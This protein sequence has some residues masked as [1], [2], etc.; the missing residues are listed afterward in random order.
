MYMSQS[1]FYLLITMYNRM[2]NDLAYKIV[3]QTLNEC[4]CTF[5]QY[6]YMCMLWDSV[7]VWGD[8]SIIAHIDKSFVLWTLEWLA[9]FLSIEAKEEPNS[10][11]HHHHTPKQIGPP[12]CTVIRKCCNTQCVY[13]WTYVLGGVSTDVLEG[14]V[15]NKKLLYKCTH[16]YVHE[17]KTCR[18][19]FLYILWPVYFWNRISFGMPTTRGRSTVQSQLQNKQ[20]LIWWHM[21]IRPHIHMYPYYDQVEPS[22]ATFSI[23]WLVNHPYSW[24][25]PCDF[26]NWWK[27]LT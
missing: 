20:E 4:T 22:R 23:F 25:Y 3:V 10:W 6:I 17:E 12:N 5:H 27:L 14:A 24:P 19:F 26:S 1:L 8:K 9:D 13:T 7:M 15:H 18:M 16:I 21:Y 2:N 11:Q